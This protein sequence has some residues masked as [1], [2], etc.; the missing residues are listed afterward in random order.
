MQT[1][2]PTLK[3]VARRLRTASASALSD[4]SLHGNVALSSIHHT[5]QAL[6]LS[7]RLVPGSRYYFEQVGEIDLDKQCDSTTAG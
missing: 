4:S 5:P 6:S 7:I 2:V 1:E 3:T